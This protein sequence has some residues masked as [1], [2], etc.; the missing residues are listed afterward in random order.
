M[1]EDPDLRRFFRDEKERLREQSADHPGPNAD[2]LG[3]QISGFVV[4]LFV[5]AVLGVICEI[6][7]LLT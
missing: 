7:R 3:A 5:L 2:Q 4:A 1:H 6:V